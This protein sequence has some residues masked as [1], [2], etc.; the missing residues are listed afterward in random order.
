MESSRPKEERNTKEHITPGNGNR[1]EKNEQGSD[2]TR[3]EGPGLSEW[4]GEYWSADYALL[5]VTG[6]IP[7]NPYAP[8]FW[9]HGFPNPLGGLPVSTNIG[10]AS[11]IRFPSSRFRKQ[12]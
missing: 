9:N 1:H 4:V 12:Q 3:K 11:D 10:K 7:G 5:G 2:R 8:L 6:V